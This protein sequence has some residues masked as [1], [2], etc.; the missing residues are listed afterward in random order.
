VRWVRHVAR[1]VDWYACKVLVEKT[2]GQSPLDRP[3]RKCH[4]NI[5]IDLQEIECKDMGWIDLY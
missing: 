5:K 1:M 3:R 4:D 2:E